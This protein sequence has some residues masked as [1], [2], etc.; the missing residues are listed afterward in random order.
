MATSATDNGTKLATGR[1]KPVTLPQL[2][3]ELSW[4]HVLGLVDDTPRSVSAL[5]QDETSLALTLT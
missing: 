4:E 1:E 3:W 2:D 5:R